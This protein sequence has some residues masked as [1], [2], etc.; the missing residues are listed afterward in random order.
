MEEMISQ[1]RRTT[2]AQENVFTRSVD[3]RM[4][5]SE[6]WLLPGRSP[7]ISHWHPLKRASSHGIDKQCMNT[8]KQITLCRLL[9]NLF[10]NLFPS[11]QVFRIERPK[12]G[13]EKA[14]NLREQSEVRTIKS[15]GGE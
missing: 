11:P 15:P 9:T 8:E 14:V 3:Q 7:I 5:A 6:G 1:K 10:A 12:V 4:I 2:S 13:D